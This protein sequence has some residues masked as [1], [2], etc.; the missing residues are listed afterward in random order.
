LG[1]PHDKPSIVVFRLV[2]NIE[3]I[4]YG[5][6]WRIPRQPSILTFWR[7]WD[8][9]GMKHC[10]EEPLTTLVLL[11]FGQVRVNEGIILYCQTGWGTGQKEDIN[12]VTTP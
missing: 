3:Q 1:K 5:K 7:M 12:P 11:T 2:Q 6:I 4:K 10:L 9:K 8:K